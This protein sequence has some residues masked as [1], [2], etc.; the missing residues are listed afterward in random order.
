MDI[1]FP[2]CVGETQQKDNGGQEF[3][4]PCRDTSSSSDLTRRIF[5]SSFRIFEV[6][7]AFC[8]RRKT[9]QNR[10]CRNCL[11]YLFW[12]PSWHALLGRDGPI[13]EEAT[14]ELEESVPT[15]HTAADIMEDTEMVMDGTEAYTEAMAP[16][17][18]TGGGSRRYHEC[19]TQ[20]VLCF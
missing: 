4:I 16:A 17:T 12:L 5:I 11:L 19:G 15:S 7:P 1:N 10:R 3:T 6:T 13:T 2:Y 20:E 18:V 9:N 8:P 14:M